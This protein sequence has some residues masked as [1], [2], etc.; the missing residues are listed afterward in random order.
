MR[1]HLGSLSDK[2]YK[3]LSRSGREWIDYN[4]CAL[5][6]KEKEEFTFLDQ[7][8]INQIGFVDDIE[9]GPAI[10]PKYVSSD[11]YLIS[12]IPAEEFIAHAE[13]HK[14]S[15]NYKEIAAKLQEADNPVLVKVKLK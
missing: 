10:W 1:F 12:F 9:G 14:V 6:N 11:N 5:F 13:K 8:E 3:M 2:P 15:A 7:P 4:S